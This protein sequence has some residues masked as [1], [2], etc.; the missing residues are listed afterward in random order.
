MVECRAA[1][2]PTDKSRRDGALPAVASEK[3]SCPS[4]LSYYEDS[5]S[6]TLLEMTLTVFQERC[7]SRVEGALK[8]NNTNGGW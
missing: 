3:P 6:R 5:S 7:Y 2:S 8:M 1:A 4:L